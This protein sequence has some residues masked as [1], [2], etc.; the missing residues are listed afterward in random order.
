MRSRGDGVAAQLDDFGAGRRLSDAVAAA[1]LAELTSGGHQP[2][3]RLAP[4]R[5]MALRFGVSRTV[6]REAVTSLQSRGVVIVRPGS[7]VFVASG[8]A[9]A[10]KESLRLLVLGT[11]ELDYGQVYEVREALEGRIAE[12][13]AERAT[14]EDGVALRRVLDDLD[15]AITG[16]DYALADGAFHLVVAD[17]AHN[18]LFRIVLDAVGDM[19]IEVRRRV[20][21][22]PAARERVAVDHRLIA[23]RILHGDRAGARHAMEEHLAHSRELVSELDPPAPR[24]PAGQPLR[25]GPRGRCRPG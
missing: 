1:L 14:E 10:A 11:R 5:E 23:D 9:L 12:L 13:A 17:A 18:R 3:D 15:A 7:G 19:I 22:Q 24:V 21:Y 16:D 25:S 20:A 6:I 4:E 8:Q 2:G